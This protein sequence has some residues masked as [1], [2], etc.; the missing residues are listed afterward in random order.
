MTDIERLAMTV[1]EAAEAIGICRSMAYRL[2]SEGEIPSLRIERSV[3][4]SI[5]ALREWVE[6]RERQGIEDESDFGP[7]AL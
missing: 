2:V 3:R 6:A 1:P 7:D 4:I 5:S